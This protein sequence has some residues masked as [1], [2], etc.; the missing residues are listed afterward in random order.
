MLWSV[1]GIGSGFSSVVIAD[2]IIYITGMVKKEGFITAVEM[3]GTVKWRKPYGP[4]W[5]KSYPGARAS[6]TISNGRLFIFSGTG[7]VACL[8]A[9]TGE[10]KWSV[11]VVE[12][13]EGRHLWWG[14][15]ESLLIVDD[16]V[17]CTTGSEDGSIIALSVDDGSMVWKTK[18]LSEEASYSSPIVIERGGKKLILQ[19]LTEYLVGVDASDGSVMCKYDM[20]EYQKPVEGGN[21]ENTN[22]PG[23]YI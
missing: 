12:K 4:E 18:E 10:K 16:K 1:D 19:L 13:F 3:D 11:D 8:D 5:N 14:Y 2:G 9:K 20:K 6:V 22:T 23:L 7:I 21:A 17:I 15:G